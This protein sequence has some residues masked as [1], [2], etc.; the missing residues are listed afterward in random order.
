MAIIIAF[1]AILLGR[2]LA[3]KINQKSKSLPGGGGE[4]Q[5]GFFCDLLDLKQNLNLH[6]GKVVTWG[7]AQS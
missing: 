1:H 6:A 2:N 3:T 4:V 5:N 7:A